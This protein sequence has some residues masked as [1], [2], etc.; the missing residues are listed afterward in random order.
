MNFNEQFDKLTKMVNNALDDYQGI[1][2]G[3]GSNI[4]KAMKYSL[5]AGGKRLRP[6]LALAVCEMLG[7]DQEDVLPYACAIEMIH[8]YSLIHDDLPAMDNDDYRRGIPT[9]HKVFGEAMAIL[10]GDALL[11]KAYELMLSYT[12][13]NDSR[14][15]E[16]IEA[17]RLIAE[18]AGADGMIRGQ[19]VDLESEKVTVSQ[20]TL[21][22][23]HKC[24][25]GAL[26]K[27][28]VLS[29]AILCGAR[30][31]EFE[32]LRIYAHSLGLAFQ[33]KDD[34]MDVESSIEIMGKASGGDAD[35]SKSTY[36]TLFGVEKARELLEEAVSA[37]VSALEGFGD[38]ADFLREMALFVKNRNH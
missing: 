28:P 20:E 10:A 27:A 33:I 2:D 4:Y 9:N 22:L 24:K 38:K 29:S 19:V 31:D 30:E 18:S 11:N 23:M 7:G 15:R 6:V 17:M 3:P 5:M 26:I 1:D 32:Q 36:V 25:T 37:A 21:E 13:E 14:Q 12:L 35:S 16:K 34:I 8:T